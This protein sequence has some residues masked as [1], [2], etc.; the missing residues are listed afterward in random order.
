MVGLESRM[1]AQSAT[2]WIPHLAGWGRCSFAQPF[3]P[4]PGLRAAAK[5][6]VT[7]C[8][9]HAHLKEALLRT[10]YWGSLAPVTASTGTT[11]QDLPNT[12]AAFASSAAG[13]GFRGFWAAS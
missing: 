10:V 1:A 13:R 3:D 2:G 8:Q 11:D 12:A 6:P 5:V 4:S 7:H 9:C